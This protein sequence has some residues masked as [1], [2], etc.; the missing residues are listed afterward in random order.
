[1][2]ETFFCFFFNLQ[3][4]FNRYRTKEMKLASCT[5]NCQVGFHVQVGNCKLWRMN[6]AACRFQRCLA[7]G[8]DRLRKPYMRSTKSPETKSIT[9]IDSP[10]TENVTSTEVDL[11]TIV[12]AMMNFSSE[13]IDLPDCPFELT[14]DSEA[15][16]YCMQ[17]FNNFL[18]GMKR[19]I[20][21]LVTVDQPAD[22][23]R[24]PHVSCSDI[25]MPLFL[26]EVNRTSA[27][28]CGPTHDSVVK[29]IPEFNVSIRQCYPNNSPHPLISL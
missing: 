2:R 13:M 1:M 8:L 14:T 19:F 11:T 22:L 26:A 15:W 10:S 28:Y 9:I 16:I 17:T 25:L 23:L 27:G 4:F 29:L 20:S 7:A 21:C 6:C 5:K 12:K 3:K 18:G 24:D